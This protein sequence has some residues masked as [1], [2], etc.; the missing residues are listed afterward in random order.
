MAQVRATLRDEG[1]LA[2]SRRCTAP[3]RR[4]GG[5]RERRRA[6]HPRR[7]RPELVATGPGRSGVGESPSC[8]ARHR[9]GT[10]TCASSWTYSH[11]VSGFP[12]AATKTG[13]LAKQF[14]AATGVAPGVVHADRAPR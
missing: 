14:I 1:H 5:V 7:A 3:P 11:H 8:A 6:G 12:I 13:E 9:A 10:T 2:A 4:A